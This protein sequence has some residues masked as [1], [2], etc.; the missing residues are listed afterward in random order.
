[1]SSD[2][3][4]WRGPSRSGA[5]GNQEI[6][7]WFLGFS[8]SALLSYH[9][10]HWQSAQLSQLSDMKLTVSTLVL[11]LSSL[12]VL[13]V[14]GVRGPPRADKSEVRHVAKVGD[15]LKIKCPIQGY[16][17]PI[18]SWQKDQDDISYAWS[19]YR[20]TRRTLKIKSV[21]KEDQGIYVCKGINGFGKAETR[22]ELVVISPEDFP[23]IVD[24]D[25]PN[26]AEPVFTKETIRTIK[27][28]SVVVG[29]SVSLLCSAIGLPEPQL[30]WYKN[31][32]LYRD[33]GSSLVIPSVS[34]KDTGVYTCIA[35]NMVGSARVKYRLTVRE[36]EG[37]E[38]PLSQKLTVN[39]GS[40][41]LIDCQVSSDSRPS[42]KWLKK[43][44]VREVT[45]TL[46]EGEADVISVGEEHYRIIGD[47]DSLKQVSATD[48]LSQLVVKNARLEDRG[49]YICFVT[50]GGQAGGFNFK[51][52]YLSVIEEFAKE[53]EREFPVM[54][55]VIVLA[56]VLVVL[57]ISLALCCRLYR[58]HKLSDL[59]Q[60][61]SHQ[62]QCAELGGA[63]GATTV[64]QKLLW[65][66]QAV[67]NMEDLLYEKRPMESSTPLHPGTFNNLPQSLSLTSTNNNLTNIYHVVRPGHFRRDQSET[68]LGR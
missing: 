42:V 24:S 2:V 14:S 30:S 5:R 52:S 18:I 7:S 37:E 13:L 35:M 65:Q 62:A 33:S 63:G 49:M 56:L 47:D 41:A 59:S 16:P 11:S 61:S 46:D 1:M 19:R 23:D 60:S 36:G 15:S 51:Q 6:F 3:W 40:T 12:Q 48:W 31:N 55:V 26:L 68:S 8:R 58:R 39:Y 20:T 22:I 25:I 27:E 28:R 66:G 50:S 21:I 38:E 53:V 10:R 57:I 9:G 45:E 44:E 4:C 29:E 67:T 34:M 64:H 17:Q 43:L 54:A 32:E